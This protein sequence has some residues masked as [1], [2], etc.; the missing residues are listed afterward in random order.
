[1]G[2]RGEIFVSHV[3]VTNNIASDKFKMLIIKSV[4]CIIPVYG[5]RE[6]YLMRN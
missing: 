3:D 6:M 2:G 1:M 4:G 5:K